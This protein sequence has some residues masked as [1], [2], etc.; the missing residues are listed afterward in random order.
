M[1]SFFAL[2]GAIFFSIS[3]AAA[4]YLI[5]VSPQAS[6]MEKNAAQEMKKYAGKLLGREIPIVNHAGAK[7]KYIRI[8]STAEAAA[9]LQVD[10]AKFGDSEL[11]IKSVDSDLYLAGGKARGSLY[12]VYE[13][14]ERFC[15]VRFLS[16]TEEYIPALKELPEADYRFAPRIKVRQI[17]QRI[18]G[19]EDQ[20]FAAKR[21][22]NG[23]L[24]KPVQLSANGAVRNRFWVAT[25]FCASARRKKRHWLPIRISMP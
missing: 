17:S 5:L 2:L 25:P 24:N 6:E 22:L 19:E 13:Y 12:A 1:S 4:D 3:A 15:N 21:R 7:G 8:G 20:A 10:F 11:I 23:I 14:L 18:S 9:V 16:P